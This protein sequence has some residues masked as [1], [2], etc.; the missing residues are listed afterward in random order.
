MEERS[1][2]A[3]VKDAASDLKGTSLRSEL[4]FRLTTAR[5]VGAATEGMMDLRWLSLAECEWKVLLDELERFSRYVVLPKW[6]RRRWLCLR[7]ILMRMSCGCD[8]VCRIES[9]RS[10]W[11]THC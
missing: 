7:C 2:I 9:R 10:D 11:K 6:A 1:E 8:D 3:I 5:Q 4:R